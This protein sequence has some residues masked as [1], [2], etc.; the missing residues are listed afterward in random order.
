M[1]AVAKEDSRVG[2]VRAREGFRPNRQLDSR[3]AVWVRFAEMKERFGRRLLA[4]PGLDN[5]L[6]FDLSAFKIDHRRTEHSSSIGIR[7]ALREGET[8]AYSD[9]AFD[10]VSH[11]APAHVIK[12][13]GDRAPAF[14][15]AWFARRIV[16]INYL[17]NGIFTIQGG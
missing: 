3:L 16:T 1:Y 12:I 13:G 5:N 2:Q 8:F 14:Q 4:I 9:A 15:I 17:N 10:L 6:A 7:T 11:V